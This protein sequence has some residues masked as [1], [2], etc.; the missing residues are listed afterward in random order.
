MVPGSATLAPKTQALRRAYDRSV[1]EGIVAY[2]L[3]RDFTVFGIASVAGHM[4]VDKPYTV[5]ASSSRPQDVTCDC[6]AGR[7][8]RICKHAA[9]A[10]FCRKYHV[11]AAKPEARAASTT[12]PCGCGMSTADPLWEAYH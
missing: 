4:W 5:R 10:T 6:E 12:C 7:H 3:P 2:R 9:V 8:G 1:S 11:A